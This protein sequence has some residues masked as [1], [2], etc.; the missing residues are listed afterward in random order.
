MTNKGKKKFCVNG[1]DLSIT[2]FNH[3]GAFR[4][5]LCYYSQRREYT[6]LKSAIKYLRKYNARKPIKPTS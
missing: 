1:H 3:S 6:V 4:C 2:R 5:S